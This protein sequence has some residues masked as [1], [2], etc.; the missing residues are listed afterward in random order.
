MVNAIRKV[1]GYSSKYVIIHEN[2]LIFEAK[3]STT[4]IN[5]DISSSTCRQVS[6]KLYVVT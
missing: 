5:T 2:M 3:I 4:I 1:N 6:V